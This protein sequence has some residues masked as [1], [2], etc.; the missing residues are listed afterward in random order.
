MND[1]IKKAFYTLLVAIVLG[2]VV[3][4]TSTTSENKSVSLVAVTERAHIYQNLKEIKGLL[5]DLKHHFGL[6]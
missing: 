2:W 5:R 4:V 6:P 3:W 1:N